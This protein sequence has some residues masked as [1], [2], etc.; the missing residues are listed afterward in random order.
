MA[1]IFVREVTFKTI[2]DAMKG[3]QVAAQ[4]VKFYKESVGV[5]VQLQRALSGVPTRVRF[6]AQLESLDKWQADSAK[7]IQDPAFHRLLAEM[8]PLVDGTKTVD[9]LWAA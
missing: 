2:A 7:V 3:M 6:V 1:N 4:V 9:E 8:A 5:D